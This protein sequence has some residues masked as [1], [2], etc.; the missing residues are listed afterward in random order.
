MRIHHLSLFLPLTLFAKNPQTEQPT[1]PP[2]P[3]IEERTTILKQRSLDQTMD[4]FNQIAPCKCLKYDGKNLIACMDYAAKKEVRATFAEM[5]YHARINYLLSMNL[6]EY[7]RFLDA[8][9]NEKQWKETLSKL[10]LKEQR[11]LPQTVLEQLI[12]IRD[13]WL[14]CAPQTVGIYGGGKKDPR[15]HDIAAWRN[16]TLERYERL[17]ENSSILWQWLDQRFMEQKIKLLHERKK[18]SQSRKKA[19]S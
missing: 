8:F 17:R 16:K 19:H 11:L 13:T 10:P 12:M 5:S 2:I 4:L 15:A 7:K 18:E 6:L 3:N 1:S 9:D 14:S